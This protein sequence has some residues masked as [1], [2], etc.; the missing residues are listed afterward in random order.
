[1]DSSSEENILGE[2]IKVTR[3]VQTDFEVASK[4]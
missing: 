2:G 4:R 1:M 3:E